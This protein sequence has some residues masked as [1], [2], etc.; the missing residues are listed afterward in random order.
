VVAAATSGYLLLSVMKSCNM[1]A[2]TG[3]WTVMGGT[4]CFMWKLIVYRS[5]MQLKYGEQNGV[6]QLM[7]DNEPQI[8]STLDSVMG[9]VTYSVIHIV[10]PWC[11]T[12]RT[13]MWT[14]RDVSLKLYCIW[15]S[16]NTA[17]VSQAVLL[18]TLKLYCFWFSN[19]IASDCQ[20]MF[21]L[22]VT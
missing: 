16:S 15:L 4:I 22:T 3:S 13:A 7:C 19:N 2:S 1:K 20:A 11:R 5:D 12:V 17:S 14:D 21:L 8:R 18:L 6:R 10:Q 9:G